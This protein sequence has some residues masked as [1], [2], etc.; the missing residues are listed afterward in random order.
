MLPSLMQE[1]DGGGHC[2]SEHVYAF[3][4]HATERISSRVALEQRETTKLFANAL[5]TPGER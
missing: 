2:P 3:P 5:A 4:Q 1:V